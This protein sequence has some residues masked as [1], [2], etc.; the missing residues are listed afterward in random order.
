M[1][2]NNVASVC[3]G[4]KVGQTSNFLLRNNFQ[5]HATCD[6]VC[7][8]TQHVTSNNVASVNVCT[9]LKR[10]ARGIMKGYRLLFKARSRLSGASNFHI[11]PWSQSFPVLIYLQKQLSQDTFHAILV[12]TKQTNVCADDR[13]NRFFAGIKVLR[14]T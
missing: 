10:G 1:L 9:G 3:T 14:I 11:S 4:L 5:Q 13:G 7:K 8:W 2:A 12:I 6:R